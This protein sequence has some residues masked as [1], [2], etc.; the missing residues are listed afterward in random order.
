M[1]RITKTL[2]ASWTEYLMD[3][4]DEVPE[5]PEA[6]RFLHSNCPVGY[7]LE[8]IKC[9]GGE[10]EQAVFIFEYEKMRKPA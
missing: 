4:F 3:E 8:S 7:Y 9:A 6:S 2:P 1:I 10:D 5:I